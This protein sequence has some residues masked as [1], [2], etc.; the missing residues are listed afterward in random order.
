MATLRDEILTILVKGGRDGKTRREL[1]DEMRRQSRDDW[2][3]LGELLWEMKCGGLVK[4][5]PTFMFGCGERWQLTEAGRAAARTIPANAPTLCDLI[6]ELR[7]A[8]G[9]SLGDVAKRMG[10]SV[11]QVANV[12]RAGRSLKLSD[13]KPSKP[14]A[15]DTCFWDGEDENGNHV[16]G[17]ARYDGGKWVSLGG[18]PYPANNNP[19]G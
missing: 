7:W 17:L 6:R 19:E 2:D 16:G 11:V 5:H 4:S 14:K 13:F 3:A 1:H 12:E 10:V 9:L 8:S 18:D 15:G